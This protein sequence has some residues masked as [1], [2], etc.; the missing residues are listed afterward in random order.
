MIIP[1][2]HP[3]ARITRRTLIIVSALLIGALVSG[4]LAY[5]H[6]DDASAARKE[7]WV[8]GNIIS[9]AAFTDNASMSVQDIQAF[10]DR[11]VG[12]CDVWGSGTAVEF[13]YNGTRAQ[14]A[15]ANGW[16]APPYTCLNMYYEVPK[17]APGGGMPANN[18]S[19]PGSRPAGS[20]SAAWIIRDAADRYNISPRV[21]LVKLATES[22][23]PLT[24]D[25]WPLLSQ[26]RY[27][28]G[29]YCPDSGPGGSANCNESYA[30][31]S[32]Q[33]YKAAELLRY[34]LNNMNQPWWPHKK[35][36]INNIL[37]NVVE[38]GCGGA[39]VNIQ[40]KATAALY[41]YTPY[42]PNQA[43]LNNMYG[44]GDNCS[45][46]G[47]RNFWRVFW[48]W[49]GDTRNSQPY[50]WSLSSMSIYSDAERTNLIS[51]DGNVN[52]QPGQTA[53]V[54]VVAENTGTSSWDDSTMLETTNHS[55]LRNS[56][57]IAYNKTSH[58]Q[59]TPVPTGTSTTFTYS[60]KAPQDPGLYIQ[61]FNLHHNNSN[62]WFNSTNLAIR[63]E[64][65]VPIDSPPI[66]DE[67][68][69][70]TG[71]SMSNGDLLYSPER[72]SV[73]RFQN[74]K[75]D[76]FV[77]FK[78][79][80]SSPVS[81]SS[82]TKFVN[83]SDGNLVLYNPSGVPTWASGTQSGPSG[84]SLQVDGNLVLYNSGS[85]IWATHTSSGN[86]LARVN[87]HITPGSILLPKQ[88]LATYDRKAFL[89]LQPDGNL[90]LYNRNRSPVWATGTDNK[91]VDRVI[92]QQD[93]NI[94]LY[95]RDGRAVWA[96]HT[97]GRGAKVL[98]LQDDLNLVMYS[99]SGQALWASNTPGR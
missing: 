54:T 81:N 55:V 49:F 1:T 48:D 8:T 2:T 50:R 97:D 26:Y 33:M 32:L 19:N 58:P 99:N 25:K 76:L 51:S 73:L 77:N 98:V 39:D 46:Y 86:Q 96:S 90:V 62:T 68:R 4:L 82:A 22:A 40:N 28:M 71:K 20:Q 69:L 24:S 21:L 72:H 53:Y 78:N 88:T 34:Y 94:V 64:V 57:W 84:L 63:A 93:G 91:N 70:L 29:A 18:Y 65:V 38:R 87:T 11:N 41:T 17:T 75:L 14:Y 61:Q 67:N 9:D 35:P 13:G 5:I 37:W 36:G 45:A 30:G 15:A 3:L 66:T 42:Q 74:G 92:F 83:Q 95:S 80:W 10:L 59:T 47:N 56:D 89:V 23:G 60:I 44:T 7:D 31:F 12:S 16:Q 52:L 43:A 85:P 79:A 6:S 27:A